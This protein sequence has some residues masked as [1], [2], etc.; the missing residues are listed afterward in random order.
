MV[1]GLLIIVKPMKGAAAVALV[2]TVVLAVQG[3][4]QLGLG[5]RIRPERGWWWP[6]VAGLVT[7]AVAGWLVMRF[8]YPSVETA[9]EMAGLAMALAGLA[10][11]V[12]G[13]SWLAPRGEATR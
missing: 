10:F 12:M 6:V 11:I 8:P 7:L 4:T 5:L 3:V 1:G 9:G 13:A 2:V